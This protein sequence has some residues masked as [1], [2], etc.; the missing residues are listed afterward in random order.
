MKHLG[1]VLAI[2]GILLVVIGLLMDTSYCGVYNFRPGANNRMAVL[3]LGACCSSEVWC[4]S[5]SGP[6][7]LRSPR[8]SHCITRRGGQ[9]CQNR[10]LPRDREVHPQDSTN[11]PLQ[12]LTPKGGPLAGLP[13]KEILRR[14]QEEGAINGTLQNGGG[15][16]AIIRTTRPRRRSP[17]RNP[18]SRAAIARSPRAATTNRA[19]R[20]E[21]AL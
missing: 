5:G 8:L 11:K 1:V 9:P 21:Y 15:G 7:L 14:L 12:R 2:I 16:L 18:R 6:M 19:L 10:T 4:S 3:S 17:H 20:P 13:M